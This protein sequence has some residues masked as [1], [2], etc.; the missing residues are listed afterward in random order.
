MADQQDKPQGEKKEEKFDFD[1]AGEV[2]GWITLEQARVLAIQHARD[3]REIYGSRYAR[4][5]LVWEVLSAEE[6]EDLLRVQAV[7]P[8]GRPVPG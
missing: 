8:P 1:S 6:G 2:R 5:D 4:T 3:N 7:V